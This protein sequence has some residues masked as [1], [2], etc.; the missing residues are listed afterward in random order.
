[1]AISRR[2]KS[3]GKHS[4]K[5]SKHHSTHRR[6]VKNPH[7]RKKSSKYV[8]S[9]NKRKTRKN[10]NGGGK[11]YY[12]VKD[13]KNKIL[14]KGYSDSKSRFPPN[15]YNAPGTS[16]LEKKIINDNISE[17]QTSLK[18]IIQNNDGVW[19]IISVDHL[20]NGGTL[21]TL[22]DRGKIFRGTENEANFFI[23]N[24]HP[25]PIIPT[26][27]LGVHPSNIDIAISNID[28]EIKAINTKTGEEVGITPAVQKYISE[29]QTDN[30][31]LQN[32]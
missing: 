10:I 7:K 18:D 4:Y 1:M 15:K 25:K 2:R 24:N 29:A 5:R 23:R 22:S 21:W 8:K 12:V 31:P 6:K 28:G 11:A 30:V 27:L 26:E 19:D 32:D 9:K 3:R 13:N 14:A 17:K 20:Y 16:N